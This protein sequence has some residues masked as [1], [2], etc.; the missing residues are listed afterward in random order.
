MKSE[1]TLSP[2]TKV[3]I[4]IDTEEKRGVLSLEGTVLRSISSDVKGMSIQFS[5][6]TPE[7]ES[8]IKRFLTNE[9]ENEEK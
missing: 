4:S 8:F 3:T 6:T 5:E 9:D 7:V 2:D 1:K